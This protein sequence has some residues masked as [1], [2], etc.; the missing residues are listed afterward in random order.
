V[1]LKGA[2]NIFD[3]VHEYTDKTYWKPMT[4]ILCDLVCMKTADLHKTDYE[5]LMTVAGDGSSSAYKP[6]RHKPLYDYA[7]CTPPEGIWELLEEEDKQSCRC[8]GN[9]R[10]SEAG[11]AGN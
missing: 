9:L 2:S 1:L 10:S 3:G 7:F 5:T 4:R 8:I 6:L 11:K